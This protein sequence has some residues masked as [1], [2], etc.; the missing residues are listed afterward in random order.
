MNNRRYTCRQWKSKRE[1][2]KANIEHR[3]DRWGLHNPKDN[4]CRYKYRYK[5]CQIPNMKIGIKN[6]RVKHSRKQK[7]NKKRMHQSKRYKHW[8]NNDKT[9]P[10]EVNKSWI[11]EIWKNYIRPCRSQ[12]HHQQWRLQSCQEKEKREICWQRMAIKNSKRLPERIHKHRNNWW[13]EKNIRKET[14]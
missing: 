6:Q 1:M 11:H 13:D 2:G 4:V 3:Q 9:D 7:M 5:R 12:S 14:E 8:Y 10:N